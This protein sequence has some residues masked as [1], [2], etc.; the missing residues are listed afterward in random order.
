VGRPLE[1]RHRRQRAADLDALP[2]PLQRVR[3]VDAH[4]LDLLPGRLQQ[5]HRR[6]DPNADLPRRRRAT[7]HQRH[8]AR[9]GDLHACADARPRDHRERR[10]LLPRARIQSARPPGGRPALSRGLREHRLESGGELHQ[11]RVRQHAHRQRADRPD[12]RSH[13]LGDVAEGRLGRLV[14]VRRRLCVPPADPADRSTE[15]LVRL[16]HV[17]AEQPRRL[18]LR[19]H[20]RGADPHP[21]ST[22]DDAYLVRRR[23]RAQR[24]HRRRDRLGAD[25]GSGGDAR[26]GLLRAG[27]A[28]RWSDRAGGAQ[29]EVRLVV[30]VLVRL[31]R[32]PGGRPRAQTADPPTGSRCSHGPRSRPS[33]RSTANSASRSHTT[34][35]RAATQGTGESTS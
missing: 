12:L 28:R 6:G 16:R 34:T 27:H 13:G 21:H 4:L 33:T 10:G 11:Q 18:Q 30:P 1:R 14:G 22:L 17:R 9:R 24:D 7:G 35:R 23:H 25:D 2:R 19:L 15:R 26:L 5:R 29:R 31:R 8:P 20:P 32:R 3:H